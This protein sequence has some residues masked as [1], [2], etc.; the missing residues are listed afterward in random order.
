MRML[1]KSQRRGFTLF[2]LLAVVT[3]LAILAVV[4]LPAIN[5]L[6]NRANERASKAIMSGFSQSLNAFQL[7]CGFYPST[8]QGLQALLTAPTVGSPCKNYE[9]AGYFSKKTIPNDP[10]GSPYA[11][12]S[13]GT[14]NPESFDL[15][16]LGR[17]RTEGT[18]DDIKSWE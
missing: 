16:S 5:G 9:T 13:P 10:W 8:E 11:Y 6:R 17:D 7:D 1:K 4:A 2:E 15:Y 3:I 12:K 18:S 14:A